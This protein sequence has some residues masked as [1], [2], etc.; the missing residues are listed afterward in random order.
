M[1]ASAPHQQV[2]PLSEYYS[3]KD[4]VIGPINDEWENSVRILTRSSQS[5]LLA[6]GQPASERQRE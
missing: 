1:S 5:L 4:G 2:L 3:T 6:S